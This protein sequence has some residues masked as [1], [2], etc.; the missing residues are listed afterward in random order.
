MRQKWALIVLIPWLLGFD[1]SGA[2]EALDLALHNLFGPNI[3]AGIELT[4]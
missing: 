1:G 3:F 4:M 2:R